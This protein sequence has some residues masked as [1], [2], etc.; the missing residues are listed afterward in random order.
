MPETDDS[1]SLPVPVS[2]AYQLIVGRVVA[3]EDRQE[4]LEKE[5][6]VQR[7]YIMENGQENAR[8][9]L[10]IDVLEEKL[11]DWIDWWSEAKPLIDALAV[12]MDDLWDTVLAALDD[13]NRQI[14]A[15]KTRA[16]Y[17]A[18]NGPKEGT[19]KGHPGF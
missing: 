9:E 17:P 5:V 1:G 16:S 8:N 18:H 19:G 6:D 12:R 2:Q 11:Q 3:F 7:E 10:R 13:M 4:F 15:V 14:P